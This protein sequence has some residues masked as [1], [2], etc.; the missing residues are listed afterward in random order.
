VH[1]IKILPEFECQGQRSRSPGT[2]KSATFCS[3]VVCWGAVLVRRSSR[4]RLRRWENQC[5]LSSF[6][7]LSIYLSFF[8]LFSSPILSRRRLAVYH[9][10]T[11]GKNYQTAISPHTPDNMVNFGPLAA[12]IGSLVW[13]TPA[14][15]N[16][17]RVLAS[18]LLRCRL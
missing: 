2:Q 16:G 10:S 9:S 18:L 13:G 17:F 4:V 5:M 7:F 15:F 1:C 3:A 6:F 12:K 14:N 8:F 11:H